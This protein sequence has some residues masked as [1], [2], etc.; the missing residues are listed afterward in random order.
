MHTYAQH[1]FLMNVHRVLC[2]LKYLR[3][4]THKSAEKCAYVH[5]C[6]CFCVVSTVSIT[7]FMPASFMS[8][9]RL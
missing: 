3:M 7:G 8:D 6:F 1:T 5:L 4:R 2:A 9:I